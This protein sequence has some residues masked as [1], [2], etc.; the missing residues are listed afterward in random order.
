M[1]SQKQEKEK[2]RKILLTVK[3][4]LESD[5]QSIEGLA[6]EIGISSSSIQ[7]Y[8]NEKE[9]IINYFGEAVYNLV[10]EKLSINKEAGNFKG[11][12]NFALNNIST[13]DN[14]GKFTGSKR[15]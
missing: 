3:S 13:K 1:L 2:L 8:L 9:I 4:F 5:Y 14:S 12:F 11:G 15:R 6:K 10:Q 7:R